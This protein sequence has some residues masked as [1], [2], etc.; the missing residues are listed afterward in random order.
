MFKDVIIPNKIGS[1]YIFS[2]KILSF[3]I[4][5]Y[6]VQAMLFHF[7]GSKIQLK[8]KMSI[9]L[10]NFSNQ[11]ITSAI[12]KIVTSIGKYDEIVTSLSSSAIV[13]KELQFPF[14]GRDKVEMVVAYEVEPLLPFALE[15]AVIDFMVVHE[16]TVKQHSHVMVAAVLKTDVDAHVSLFEKAEI[17]V[18][19]VT[20]DMFA[21]YNLYLHGFYV[22]KEP[23]V[24]LSNKVEKD[25]K[26]SEVDVEGQNAP[27][28]VEKKLVDMVQDKHIEM[29][30]DI[31]FDVTRVLCMSRGV[32]R[33]VRIFPSGVA[34]IAQAISKQLELSYYE[35]VQELVYSSEN[36][37]SEQI[38]KELFKLF[39]NINRSF[40]FFEKQLKQEY[41]NP[42]KLLLSGLGC[43]I[44]SF[45]EQA[46]SFFNIPVHEVDLAKFVQKM[47]I[48]LPKDEQLRI[49][50]VANMSVALLAAD[51]EINLLRSFTH[52]SEMILFYQQFFFIV[53]F[54]IIT[55]GGV[56][57]TS[58][59]E[60]QRWDRSY[61]SSKKEL[62]S[63]IEQK[64]RV[65]LQGEKNLKS[66]V[67]KAD[68]TLKKR[69]KLWFSFSK[70][71]EQSYLEYLQE[72]SVA[73]DRESLDLKIRK[74]SLEP[75]KVS[76]AGSVKD[77]EALE[78]FEE[79]LLAL[80]RLALVEKPR[81]LTFTID[82]KVKNKDKEAA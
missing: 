13:F 78:V 20:V 1:Y 65:D 81:E 23:R 57:W 67:E 41:Q 52:K 27:K 64:M 28:S 55:I 46:K 66:M 72:L 59:I 42:E 70:Q 44:F 62:I 34:D 43:T 26:A 33:A 5:Q 36:L 71:T 6:A 50:Q 4:S 56:Y 54:T 8:N 48:S 61:I 37:Y 11:A 12:K 40:S 68:E 17:K 38:E 31:G 45:T 35:V 2:K 24:R 80:K 73:I 21:L 53:F 76:I 7:K 60:L 25:Q 10:K 82:L 79:E 15:E 47:H 58:S 29:F 9:V 3:D 69:H 51:D 39:E 49:D 63:T 19:N 75:D 74:M 14:V 30:V 16:D 22:S 77:F 32:L 18:H